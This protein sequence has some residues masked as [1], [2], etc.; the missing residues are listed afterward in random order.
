MNVALFE[1]GQAFHGGEPGEQHLLV[2]GLL[3]GQTGP[4]DVHGA[5]RAV[6][7]YDVKAD[8]EA[9]LVGAWRPGQG[10]DPARRCANGGIRAV[11]A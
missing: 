9:V 3:V 10:A 5:A 4:K 6:D 1:V 8:A 2:S 11:T 7:I